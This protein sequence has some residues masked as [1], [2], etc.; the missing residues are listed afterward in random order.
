[1]IQLEQIIDMIY[2]SFNIAYLPLRKKISSLGGGE[3]VLYFCD[4]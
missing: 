4:E 3:T 1:M 2:E